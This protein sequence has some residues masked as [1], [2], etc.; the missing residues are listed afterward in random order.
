MVPG[1]LTCVSWSCPKQAWHSMGGVL[2][3]GGRA[4]AHLGGASFPVFLGASWTRS[5][6]TDVV[7]LVSM[8]SRCIKTKSRSTARARPVYL[9]LF[10]VDLLYIFKVYFEL[11]DRGTHTAGKF[12]QQ[13]ERNADPFNISICHYSCFGWTVY[14]DK[15]LY[16]SFNENRRAKGRLNPTRD[17]TKLK[18]RAGLGVGEGSLVCDPGSARSPACWKC[19][20]NKWDGKTIYIRKS[21]WSMHNIF[22]T[23]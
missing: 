5:L 3:L 23:F 20:G 15:I 14:I 11:V 1:K 7:V 22:Y 19:P 17:K 4:T 12:N 13:W 9:A 21:I 10:D 2:C 16:T 6:Y 18:A 8:S